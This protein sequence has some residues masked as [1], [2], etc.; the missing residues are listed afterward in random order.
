MAGAGATFSQLSISGPSKS[1]KRSGAET[2]EQVSGQ[3]VTFGG[4]AP[5]LRFD[6]LDL[7]EGSL[8]PRSFVLIS[9]GCGS[10]LLSVCVCVCAGICQKGGGT[11]MDR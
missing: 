9:F 8:T 5:D 3:H 2:A 10:V 4:L 6:S 11:E 1:L 7:Q